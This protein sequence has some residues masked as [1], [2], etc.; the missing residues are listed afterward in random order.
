MQMMLRPHRHGA[1][2]HQRIGVYVVKET[3]CRGQTRIAALVQQRLAAR[4]QQ[5]ENRSRQHRLDQRAQVSTEMLTVSGEGLVAAVT[6][7][8]DRDVLT[9]LLRNVVGRDARGIAERLTEF[10]HETREEGPCLG[11]YF[12]LGVIRTAVLCNLASMAPF[13]MCPF[14]CA[15]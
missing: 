5:I 3:G 4:D 8:S 15:H 14:T 1:P 10:P 2:V 7:E 13:V 6:G 12:E 11:C 9:R